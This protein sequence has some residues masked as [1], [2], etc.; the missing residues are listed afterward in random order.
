MVNHQAS[1]STD[2]VR[3][4]LNYATDNHLHPLAI[5]EKLDLPSAVLTEPD[6][7]IPASQFHTLWNTLVSESRDPNFGLHFGTVLR[8][9][10][11]SSPYGAKTNLRRKWVSGT[12]SRNSIS[13]GKAE[14]ASDST[15]TSPYSLKT[16]F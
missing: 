15:S 5:L 1:V 6:A 3:L 2:L 14:Q 13:G 10:P 4:L 9:P 7:R 16:I 12:L 11:E 8:T